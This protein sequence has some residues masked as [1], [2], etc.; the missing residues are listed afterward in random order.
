MGY[1]AI[2]GGEQAISQ[3]QGL[4][5]FLRARGGSE[6]SLDHEMISSQLW[7]LHSRALS[8]GGIYDPKL[9]SLAIKQ[10]GGDMLEA[11]FYLRAYRSTR[12]RLG[13][14][15]AH[16]TSKMRVIRRIS[17]AFKSVPGGQMLGPTPD[18]V[19]RL[20]RIALLEESGDALKEITQE[21]LSDLPAD[22]LPDTF[23]KV[24]DAL[25]EEGLLAPTEPVDHEPFDITREPLV[26]PLPRSASLATMARAET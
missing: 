23:P 18:Y 5:E 9:A 16:T 2:R 8:E 21:W 15:P 7:A 22:E 3:A 14:T 26:F 12:P 24:V 13:Q 20:F 17:S 25:R 19:Q 1:V 11:A 6:A 4:L 10:S